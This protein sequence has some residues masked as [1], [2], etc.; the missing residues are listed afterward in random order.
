MGSGRRAGTPPCCWGWA[1]CVPEWTCPHSPFLP[2]FLGN[3]TPDGQLGA[4]PPRKTTVSPIFGNCVRPRVW[5]PSSAVSETPAKSREK[6]AV[7]VPL[8]WLK[9]GP[10]KGAPAA[11]LGHEVFL[12]M[13]ALEA[14]HLAHPSPGASLRSQWLGRRRREY[15]SSGS[16]KC[17]PALG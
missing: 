3:R 6:S 10:Y 13:E 1:V 8:S 14:L 9:R 11:I 4:Q 7:T 12:R 16:P 2:V 5:L 17:H 15:G